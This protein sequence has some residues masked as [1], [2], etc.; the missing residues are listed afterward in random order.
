MK[1]IARKLKNRKLATNSVPI[2]ELETIYAV[3]VLGEERKFGQ[4]KIVNGEQ[5]QYFK[6]F[7]ELKFYSNLT[8]KNHHKHVIIVKGEIP[9]DTC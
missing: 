5:I 1:I 6:N 4:Y 9:D 7:D 2:S 3:R 8:L